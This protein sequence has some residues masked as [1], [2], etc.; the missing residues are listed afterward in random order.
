VVGGASGTGPGTVTYNVASNT[1]GARTGTITI[2]GQTF[3]ISQA[4]AACTYS[5]TPTSVSLPASGGTGAVSVTTG[6]GCS[7]GSFSSTPWITVSGS[8]PGS[9]TVGYAVAANTTGLSRSGTILVAGVTVRFT[10]AG[11]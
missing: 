2:A 10:Q 9:G 8:G 6:A 1:G 4:A 11:Q 7:W 5:V 3:T